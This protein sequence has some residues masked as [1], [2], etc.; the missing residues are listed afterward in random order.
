ML[1]P[2]EMGLASAKT[3]LQLCYAMHMSSTSSSL[4]DL[5]FLV[6]HILGCF[7]SNAISKAAMDMAC[8]VCRWWCLTW[9]L[10]SQQPP[11][12]CLPAGPPSGTSWAALATKPSAKPS[13]R[14]ASTCCTARTRSVQEALAT[15]HSAFLPCL[16]YHS[17]SG[18][19]TPALLLCSSHHS[20][21]AD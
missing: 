4:P 9:S 10:G 17:T 7:D 12:A 13:L 14:A 15:G 8:C 16:T 5:P 11:A 3:P 1:L 20:G 2:K 6:E 18:A 19:T 21:A